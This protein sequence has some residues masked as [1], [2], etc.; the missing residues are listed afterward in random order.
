MIDIVGALT[1]TAQRSSGPAQQP[2]VDHRPS[3]RLALLVELEVLRQL[4][5]AVE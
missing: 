5:E 2:V 1:L 4:L 3:Q